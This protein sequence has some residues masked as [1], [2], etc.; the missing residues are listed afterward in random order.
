MKN[1]ISYA[2]WGDNLMYW[3]GAIRNIELA[4]KFYP[5][6]I[7]RFY[8]DKNCNQELINSIKGDNV[9]VILMD[10]ELYKHNNISNRF[11]HSGLFWRFLSLGDETI[12]IVLFR[13]CDS[14]ISQR[15]VDA[16]NDWISS[17]RKFHIMRDHPYHRVPILAGMWGCRGG[18][19]NINELITGWDSY[20]KKGMYHADDQ[21]FLG[22]VIYPIAK[23]DAIE[24][25]EFGISYEC[26]VLNFPSERVDYE[27][28]GDVFDENDNRHPDY[29]KVIKN[30]IN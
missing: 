21:D 28:V 5:G 2:I 7:C 12:D 24:H 19:L 17:G 14:R 23:S 9:E 11:N 20:D 3:S 18:L 26:E 6:W 1:V 13:D 16:V 15:E 30:N 29:W 10:P 4:N 27:F 22:Q 25:S 8:I